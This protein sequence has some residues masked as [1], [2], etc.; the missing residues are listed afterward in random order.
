[1]GRDLCEWEEAPETKDRRGGGE[2][3]R[4]NANTANHNHELRL[5]TLSIRIKTGTG[6]ED[7]EKGGRQEG[8][9]K[10]F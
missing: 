5:T 6:T 4:G 8:R 2:M 3:S 10:D 1:M 7:L 9:R